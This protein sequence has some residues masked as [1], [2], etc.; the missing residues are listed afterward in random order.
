MKGSCG[1]LSKIIAT[2]FFIGYIPFAPGTFGSLAGLIF[3]WIFKPDFLQQIVILAVGFILGIASSQVVEE[4]LGTKDSKQI[5]IDEFIGYM[6]SIIFLPLTIGYV[7][8]AFLLFRFFDIL[9][10]P[11]IRNLE[12]MFSGGIGVMID[13]LTAGVITNIILQI[14]RLV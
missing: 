4:E 13:D 3:I 8:T 6:A 1:L 11:P 12:R 10:P 7:I 5:V 14:V 9:K 2:V